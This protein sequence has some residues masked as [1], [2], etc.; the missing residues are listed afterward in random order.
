M[1]GL[2][3]EELYLG[4]N[5]VGDGADGSLSVI[6]DKCRHLSSLGLESCGLTGR[7]FETSRKVAK[8]LKGKHYGNSQ[9]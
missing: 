8:A 5:D 2:K 4:Y 7:T 1:N 6:L 3:L 9:C